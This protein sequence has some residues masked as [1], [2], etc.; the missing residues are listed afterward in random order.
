MT[1]MNRRR[2]AGCLPLISFANN[3]VHIVSRQPLAVVGQGQPGAGTRLT[4]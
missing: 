4:V 1:L 2:Q 3:S